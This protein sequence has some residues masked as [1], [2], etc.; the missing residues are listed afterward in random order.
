MKYL[1][2]FNE[3][4]TSIYPYFKVDMLKS[5][6][7]FKKREKYCNDTLKRISSGSSRAVYQLND[8]MVLKLAKNTKGLDQNMNE[9]ED[10]LQQQYGSILPKVYD[11][12]FDHK[13]EGYLY[14]ISEYAKNITIQRFQEIIGVP[15]DSYVHY[16]SER[17]YGPR[18][19]NSM[20]NMHKSY[21]TPEVLKLMKEESDREDFVETVCGVIADNNLHVGDLARIGS[22]GE[23]VREGYNSVVIR[24]YG[25]T[26]GYFEK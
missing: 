22:Y 7:T 21:L 5:L 20:A 12:Y 6:D 10:W 2:R 1:K 4:I 14:V 3:D 8:K 19:N 9:Q 26:D 11:S 17:Y 18:G 16:I 13:L 24:D 23:V 15:F 25:A